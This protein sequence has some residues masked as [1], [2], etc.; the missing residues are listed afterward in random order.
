[1]NKPNV[2]TLN[3][4]KR[5]VDSPSPSGFEKNAQNAVSNI[6]TPYIDEISED[7]NGNLICKRFANNKEKSKTILLVAHID[8]IGMMVTYI[9]P[10]GFIRFTK[11]GGVDVQLLI[12]RN[13]NI[14]HNDNVIKGVIGALPIHMKKGTPKTDIDFPDMWIDIGVSNKEEALT[15]VQVGDAIILDAATHTLSGSTVTSRACDDKAGVTVL[16]QTLK[17]LSNKTIPND[18]V[19]VTTIQEEV[20]M[21]GAMTVGYN[22][23]PDV[24]IVVDVTHATDYPTVQK[25]K[26][27]EIGLGNG[28]VIPVGS[29][30]STTVQRQLMEIAKNKGIPSQYSALSG[31]SG[32]D[33]HAIQ[34]SRGGCV[35]GLLCIPCRYMHTPVECISIK[36]VDYA[37]ELLAA[38]CEKW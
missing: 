35:T 2:N 34:V 32:T 17:M 37:A 24:C 25:S 3:T 36:D 8:E 29:D 7:I 20:G 11:I 31:A 19:V 30:L 15:L 10:S 13:V 23:Q 4:L 14:L 18:I 1:M 6:V 21:R 22:I 26:Y 27:G 12:G 5:L 9:E 38:F 16:I 33:A 28:V